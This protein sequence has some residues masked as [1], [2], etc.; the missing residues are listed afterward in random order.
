MFPFMFMCYWFYKRLRTYDLHNLLCHPFILRED[1]LGY[2]FI[3]RIAV[4]IWLFSPFLV[5]DFGLASLDWLVFVGDI[6]KEKNKSERVDILYV[7]YYNSSLHIF[8]LSCE[9]V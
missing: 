3:W 8:F 6:D 9:N 2:W 7:L 1:E 4:A 5:T